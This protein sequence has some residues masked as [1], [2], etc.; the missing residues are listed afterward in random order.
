MITTKLRIAKNVHS[1][2]FLNHHISSYHIFLNKNF[3]MTD[4]KNFRHLEE[5]EKE[6]KFTPPP[7]NRFRKCNESPRCFPE[8]PIIIE[9]SIS[10]SR[11]RKLQ[12]R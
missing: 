4:K 5:S 6:K 9:R 1:K 7:P 11:K 12:R 3:N 10:E 8:N 2:N